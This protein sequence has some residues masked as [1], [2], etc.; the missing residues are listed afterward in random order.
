MLKRA[1]IEEL[2]DEAKSAWLDLCS[3]WTQT[4][5]PILMTL[6]IFFV[7]AAPIITV[8]MI[9][10]YLDSIGWRSGRGFYTIGSAPV[11]HAL[12]LLG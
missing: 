4:M 6:W 7:L 10:W 8:I 2:A 9:L 1:W 5:W 12:T 11:A 3:F